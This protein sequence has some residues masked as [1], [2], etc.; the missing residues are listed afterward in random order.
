LVL[1]RDR[2]GIK[3]L[4]YAWDGRRLVFA[5]ELRTLVWHGGIEPRPDPAALE[6]YLAFGFVPS[7][8]ALIQGVRKLPPGNVLTLDATGKLDLRQYWRPATGAV[9]PDG[10]SPAEAVREALRG[11]VRR[12]MRSDVPV[13]ILLSG[14]VDSTIV[15][16]CA[17]AETDRPLDTFSIVFRSARSAIG[18]EYNADAGYA[19]RV[20]DLL[21]ANHH[22]VVCDDGAGGVGEVESAGGADGEDVPHLLG[23]L[24]TGL[25]EPVWE[26]S[27]VSIYLMSRLARRHGV[28]V[29]LTGDGSDELFAGYPWIAAARRQELYE[30]LPFLPALLPAVALLAPPGSTLRLHAG[31]LQGSIG[32]PDAVRYERLH[33]IFG[34]A[35]RDRL[36]GGAAGGAVQP[37]LDDLLD[38]GQGRSVSRADRI[39]LLDLALWVREHFNQRVDRMTMLNSVEARVPFQDNEVVDLALGLPFAVKAPGGRSKHLLKEAFREEIPEF[40]RRRPK[41]P[42]AAPMG[43]WEQ[44]ALSGLAAE[45]LSPDRLDGAGI[46]DP[47]A[48]QQALA[49]VEPGREDRRTA[50][51]WTLVMLQL[52]AEGLRAA[53][54]ETECA[55]QAV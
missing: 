44:G 34:P 49:A 47:V 52:W 31:N 2:M 1:A 30:R 48:A 36:T 7:P 5:S 9:T 35:E 8:Y 42:F 20:A 10:A 40:V 38:G 45:V 32:Q 24:A 21:G 43:A 6:L 41:R 39:A 18:A 27:F 19:R 33:A 28:K 55:V 25:D 15:A 17:A 51:L 12:Q 50:R 13:G 26:L 16:A 54:A 37:L 4:Y 22:E 3:P 29:L 53:P 23:R 46:V 14:G 11:A